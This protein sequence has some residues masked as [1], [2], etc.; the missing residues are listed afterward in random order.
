MY[1]QIYQFDVGFQD[2]VD[3]EGEVV[4]L[5][6]VEDV[7]FEESGGFGVVEGEE[8]VF[9]QEILVD[10]ENLRVDFVDVGF[11]LGGEEMF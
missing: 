3:D 11:V 8:D 9:E 5:V 2:G 7:V 6:E 4:E 10:L 1:F